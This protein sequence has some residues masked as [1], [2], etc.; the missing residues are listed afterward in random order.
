MAK[1][2]CVFCYQT[3]ERAKEHIWPQW[4]LRFDDTSESKLHVGRHY[5][6]PLTDMRLID[7]RKQS[8]NSLVFGNVCRVCNNGWMS[9]LENDAASMIKDAA[10]NGKEASSWS[11]EQSKV[12]ATW[13]FKT[14]LMVN[15][16]SNYRRIVPRVHYRN[17]HNSLRP[18]HGVKVEVA[19]SDEVVEGREFRQSQNFAVLGPEELV[20]RKQKHQKRSYIIGL[21]LKYLLLRVTYWPDHTAKINPLS[22]MDCLYENEGKEVDFENV[23]VLDNTA[24][25]NLG[26]VVYS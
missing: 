19:L 11:V 10:D 12:V 14:V 4:V 5:G 3:R 17:L 25:L 13:A 1:T 20:M 16:G 2:Q 22:E 26:M 18:P 23:S 7:E 24:H 8:Q 15:A 21:A 6:S 9:R